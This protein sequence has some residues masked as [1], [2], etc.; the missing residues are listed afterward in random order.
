MVLEEKSSNHQSYYSSSCGEH[1]SLSN[2]IAIYPVVVEK[3]LSK[4]Q[5]SISR[6]G[7]RKSQ[8]ITKVIRVH[9]LGTM[10]VCTKSGPSSQFFLAPVQL[11]H[12]AALGNCHTAFCIS[13]SVSTVKIYGPRPWDQ[14]DKAIRSLD[15][16][17]RVPSTLT[18]PYIALTQHKRSVL[19]RKTEKIF[20]HSVLTQPTAP[21]HNEGHE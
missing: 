7:Q 17:K 19:Q 14:T 6:W 12:L 21:H 4:P 2:I 15:N 5:I 13:T 9:H 11:V 1:E 10:D 3:F 16:S 18:K 8:W 20:F